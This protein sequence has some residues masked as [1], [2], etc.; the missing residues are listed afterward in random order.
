MMSKH[1]L[2]IIITVSCEALKMS[3]SIGRFSSSPTV[4]NIAAAQKKYHYSK[5]CTVMKVQTVYG[6]SL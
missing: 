6:S 3:N 4:L 1:V 2:Q 5:P